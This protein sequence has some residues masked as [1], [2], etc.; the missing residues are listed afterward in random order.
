MTKTSIHEF[1]NELV[2]TSPID[3]MTVEQL[4]NEYSTEYDGE[5]RIG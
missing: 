4:R 2:P 1:N 3:K 5:I